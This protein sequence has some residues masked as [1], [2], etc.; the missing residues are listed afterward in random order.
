MVA[1]VPVAAADLQA[2]GQSQLQTLQHLEAGL[3]EGVLCTKTSTHSS[4]LVFANVLIIL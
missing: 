2:L 4:K 3:V 1:A